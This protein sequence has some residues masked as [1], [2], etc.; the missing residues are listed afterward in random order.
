MPRPGGPP[1]FK[2]VGKLSFDFVPERMPHREKQLKTLKSLFHPLMEA[3]LSQNALLVGNVGTGKTHLSKRFC[4]DF[5]EFARERGKNVRWVLVNCRQRATEDSVLLAILKKWDD[6]FPERGFSIPEK[7]NVL[8]KHLERERAH[9]IAVLDEADVLLK[10]GSDLIYNL[11]RFDE[12]YQEPRGSISLIL[13]SQRNILSYLDRSTL[14]TFKRNNVVEFGKYNQAELR[15]ILMDRVKLAFFPDVVRGEC[16]NLIADIAS[17][18]G[19][20]RYA[21]EVLLRAGELALDEDMREVVPEHVREA[22][23]TTHALLSEEALE[24]LDRPKMIALLALARKLEKK[25][26]VTTGEA[27]EAY[28]LASEEFGERKRGHTQFWKYIQDLDALGFIEAKPSG[29]GVTGKTT[30][31]SMQEVPARSLIESLE[32]SLLK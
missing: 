6:R 16:L 32:A 7:L 8:R 23:A 24:S 27:E 1:I 19:D 14:S 9:L 22:R 11:T 18:Y 26:Y 15:D 20:A 2:D 4:L 5:E 10:K 12:E 31:I 21:I 13:I 28:A 17:D 25:A 3:N 30:I 29:E